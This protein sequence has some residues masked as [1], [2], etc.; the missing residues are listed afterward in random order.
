MRFT[1]I[2]AF[3]SGSKE[4]FYPLQTGHIMCFL[5]SF[6]SQ[7]ICTMCPISKGHRG[8]SEYWIFYA[9]TSRDIFT[10][11]TS[12]DFQQDLNMFGLIQS[13]VIVSMRFK[14]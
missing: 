13:W 2:F 8:V 5:W 14:R 1:S 3:P 9:P 7:R 10:A 6:N 12:L 4:V 11:K